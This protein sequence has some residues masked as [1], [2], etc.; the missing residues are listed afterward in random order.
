MAKGK[1]KEINL[2]EIMLSQNVVAAWHEMAVRA[3]LFILYTKRK[4]REVFIPDERARINDDGS[5]T[6]FVN[7]PGV[8]EISMRVPPDEWTYRQ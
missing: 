6:I 2:D 5:L 3:T 4:K 8:I 1:G 7:I